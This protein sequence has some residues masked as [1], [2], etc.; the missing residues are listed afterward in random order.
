[1]SQIPITREYA[2]A[3][4]DWCERVENRSLLLDKFAFPKI[5][6]DGNKENSA[7][8]WSLMRIASNG[9]ILLQ[10]KAADLE[11]KARGKNVETEEKRDR[12]LEEARHCRALSGTKTGAGLEP[13]RPRHTARF[14]ELLR[15]AYPAERL[16]ILNGLLEGRLAINLAEGLIQ[17]AGIMLDRIFGLPFI[18]GSA[19]K[20][21]VRATAL[22]EVRQNPALLKT[23]ARVFGTAE[24]D[25]AQKGDLKDFSCPSGLPQTLQGAVVFMQA[26]PTNEA[27]IVAD[28]TTVHYPK[29][30]RTGNPSDEKEEGPLPNTF[31]TVERGAEFAFPI[32]LNRLSDDITLLETAERWLANAMEQHG[33]GAKTAA[34]YGWFTDIGKEKQR[35]AFPAAGQESSVLVVSRYS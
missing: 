35:L 30:Y 3:V 32:L 8:F 6:G 12:L 33:F 14:L 11:R 28:I 13:L 15:T 5:W 7:S 1:M 34:G 27:K 25:Y 2:A 4:G 21:V 23:F 20:G 22:A 10:Q 18:P 26:I 17:N 29:Y 24:S 31:P 16:R 19:V 9:A